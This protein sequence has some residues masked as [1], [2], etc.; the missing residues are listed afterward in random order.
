VAAIERKPENY[1]PLKLTAFDNWLQYFKGRSGRSK[2]KIT[3]YLARERQTEMYK[4]EIPP[5][6]DCGKQQKFVILFCVL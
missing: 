4:P 2:Q 5:I 3:K 6:G 1:K